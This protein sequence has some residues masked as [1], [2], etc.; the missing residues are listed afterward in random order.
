MVIVAAVNTAN[1]RMHQ[2]T[3]TSGPAYGSHRSLVTAYLH[4]VV[5]HCTV[6]SVR[7]KNLTVSKPYFFIFLLLSRPTKLHNSGG[8]GGGGVVTQQ[9]CNKEETSGALALG[10]QS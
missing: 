5:P 3:C 8:G 2:Y 6:T 10:A 1:K 4:H 9:S 7:K